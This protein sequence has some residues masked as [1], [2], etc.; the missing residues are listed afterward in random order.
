MQE[1]APGEP[2]TQVLTAL[3]VPSQSY[4]RAR[5]YDPIVGRFRTEDPVGFSAGENF[6]RYVYNIPAGLTDPMGLSARDVQRIQALCKKCTQN[7][8]DAGKRR[9]GEGAF[10]GFVNDQQSLWGG[11][12]NLAKGGSFWAGKE[13]CKSQAVDTQPCL[14][15]PIPPYD[16]NWNFGLAP[17]WGGSHTVVVG[18]SSDPSDPMVYCDPWRG[19]SW[20]AP[21][22]RP[23]GIYFS[24]P[25]PLL[26]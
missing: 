19:K 12:W 16:A 15:G 11:L 17:W 26:R 10:R 14:E 21:M 13:G 4:Y 18:W 25:L 3:E 23:G 9:P 20:S 6:Y 7:L 1:I 22:P 2:L 8:T 24:G 5:Y